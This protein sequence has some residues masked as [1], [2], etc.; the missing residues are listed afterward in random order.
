MQQ[1]FYGNKKEMLGWY[2]SSYD[3]VLPTYT[4]FVK[5]TVT[6]NEEILTDVF[7]N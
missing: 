3:Y 4:L 1:L 7:I 2:S 6:D 5:K